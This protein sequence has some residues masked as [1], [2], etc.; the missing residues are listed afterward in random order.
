MWAEL[1]HDPE[2][3]VAIAFIIAVVVVARKACATVTA[4]LDARTVKIKQEIDEAQRLREE[5][6]QTLAQFQRK[7]RDALQEAGAII[8]H[9]REEAVRNAE[10]AQREL[11]ASIVRRERLA[12][13]KIALAESKAVAEIRGVAVDVAIGA[14]RRVIAETLGTDRAVALVDQAIAELPQRLN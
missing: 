6:Q 9:A 12:A 4:I 10:R 3:A 1:F 5:A 13:E 14:A 7:Q 11:E 2:L 8:A